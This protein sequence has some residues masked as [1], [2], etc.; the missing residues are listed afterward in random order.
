MH[1]SIKGGA[2][3]QCVSTHI[4]IYIN[5]MYMLNLGGNPKF[6]LSQFCNLRQTWLPSSSAPPNGV[7]CATRA[8]SLC[9]CHPT[10]APSTCLITPSLTKP[11]T[12]PF[13]SP[14]TPNRRSPHLVHQLIVQWARLYVTPHN[15]SFV[16]PSGL[17]TVLPHTTAPPC[18]LP[19]VRWAH[20][21]Q[22]ENKRSLTHSLRN[23]SK[24]LHAPHQ[25]YLGVHPSSSNGGPWS[26]D[27]LQ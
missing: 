5:F 26:P 19:I 21:N 17:T 10:W 16:S 1:N 15:P 13:I 4:S 11:N 14:G 24:S 18:R 7:I 23:A 8:R 12:S 27:H 6:T 20:P 9:P 2:N 25:S 3:P 22:Q